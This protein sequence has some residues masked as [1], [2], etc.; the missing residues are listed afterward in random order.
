[1]SRTIFC[2]FLKH[3][4]E[5]LDFQFYPGKIGKQIFI[6]NLKKPGDNG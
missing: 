1:M 6:K 2:T 5:G 3:E 4:V